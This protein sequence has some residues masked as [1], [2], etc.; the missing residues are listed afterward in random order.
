MV[1]MKQ[2]KAVSLQ[3]SRIRLNFRNLKNSADMLSV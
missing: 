3:Y 2:L 1:E